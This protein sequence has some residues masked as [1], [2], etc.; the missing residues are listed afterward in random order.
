MRL[1]DQVVEDPVVARVHHV[2]LPVVR[3]EVNVVRADSD[4]QEP[5]FADPVAVRVVSLV[6]VCGLDSDVVSHA[7][8]VP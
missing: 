7:S 4:R 5:L 8:R 6:A 1:V 3:A 2:R